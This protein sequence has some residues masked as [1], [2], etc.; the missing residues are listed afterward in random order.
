MVGAVQRPKENLYLAIL[1][2]RDRIGVVPINVFA[3]EMRRKPLME[4]LDRRVLKL[5]ECISHHQPTSTP[6]PVR[7]RL[8]R[9]TSGH[10][11]SDATRAFT[12]PE[13]PH[14]AADKRIIV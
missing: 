3:E 8:L 11:F 5:G 4:R 1:E 10:N 6:Y 12:T 13:R 14:K 9:Q 7:S 2:G